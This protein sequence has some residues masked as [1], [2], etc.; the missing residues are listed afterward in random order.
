MEELPQPSPPTSV[1]S[2]KRKQSSEDDEH[3]EDDSSKAGPSKR[4]RKRRQPVE[5]DDE[6]KGKSSRGT[7][8]RRVAESDN[9]CDLTTKR[10]RYP[11]MTYNIA[12]NCDLI[13]GKVSIPACKKT[14]KPAFSFD[15]MT[16]K[17]KDPEDKKK[18][19][20]DSGWTFSLHT[21]VTSAIQ[22]ATTR[23]MIAAGQT[24][25]TGEEEP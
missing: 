20:K 12:K 14:S 9:V 16:F 17:R 7:P 24:P 19:G 11:P 2:K 1:R 5:E 15:G 21:E 23:A 3:S 22:E 18:K 8:A 10:I 25:Y 4:P 13:Y 6:R